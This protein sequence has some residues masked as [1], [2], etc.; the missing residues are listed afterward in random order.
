M[1]IESVAEARLSQEVLQLVFTIKPD[2]GVTTLN[3]IDNMDTKTTTT[4]HGRWAHRL[5]Q[6]FAPVRPS[7]EINMNQLD[8]DAAVKIATRSN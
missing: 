2:M 4:I 6:Y 1:T 5:P 7:T 3:T 8:I